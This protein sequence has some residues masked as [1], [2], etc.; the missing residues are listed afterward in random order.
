MNDMLKKTSITVAFL[1]LAVLCC[2]AGTWKIHP[3]F[4]ANKL[5]NIYD[6]GDKVYLLNGGCLFQY[7]KATSSF[8][9]LNQQNV[10]SDSRISQIYFDWENR[11]LFVAYYNSNIDVID[12]IGH[13]TNLS[14]MKDN[15]AKIHNYTFN[16]ENELDSYVGRAI[17]DINFGKGKA[18]VAAGYGF[19]VIDERTLRVEKNYEA[20][21]TVTINSVALMGDTLLV[22]TD[23]RCYYGSPGDSDPIANYKSS[24]GVFS[25]CKLY[26]IN[27]QSVFVYGASNGLYKYSF[28]SGTPKLTRLSTNVVSNVQKSSNGFIVNYETKSYSVFDENGSSGSSETS[29]LSRASAYP[30]GDGTIWVL[31]AGGLH[32]SGSSDCHK[33]NGTT[34]DRPHW[35]K[36]N[37]ELDRLYAGESG[38]IISIYTSTS[39]PNVINT[40]DGTNWENA[41][42]YVAPGAGYE[43]VFSPNDAHTY[44]RAS[45]NNGLFKVKDNVKITNY[46]TT[47]S[48]IRR[49]KPTPAF[50]KYGNLWVVG[51]FKVNNDDE[52]NSCV[53]LPKA[54]FE[55][56]NSLKGD[57]FVPTSLR[58]LTTGSMQRSR[59]IV[60]SKNN[61]KIFSD[62]DFLKGYFSGHIMCWD[63]GVED[64]TVDNYRFVSL[65]KFLD[66]N[67]KVIDWR[68]LSHFE[69]DKDGMIWAGHTLG[70]FF[71]DPEGVFDEFPHAVRPTIGTGYLCEGHTVYD[72]GVDRDNNKW[73]AS[74][75]GVYFVSPDG[76]EVYDHFTAENSD[77]PSNTVYSVEC[78]TLNGRVYAFT[79]N[80]LVEYVPNGDVAALNFNDVYVLPN[81]VEPDFT[82]LIKIGNLMEHSY[83]TITDGDGNIVA[84]LGPAM[85]Y[86]LWDGCGTDGDRVPSGVYNI[87]AAQGGQPTTTGT[88]QATVII[89]K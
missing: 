8:T 10:L 62:C 11:M 45:W 66:Q 14:N 37:A 58:D 27:G 22:L 88:P 42:A 56:V 59:F 65:G 46:T 86:V 19:V 49:Y 63:N 20:K 2:G 24:A 33:I 15:I 77:L 6:T 89:I 55:K 1:L 78:D 29:T 64:P 4:N 26:P 47:N 36:Y 71:F 18:Y 28:S 81:P 21:Q 72:I 32:V 57:W 51:S 40:Y 75:N 48:K 60:A 83:V 7:D 85:G 80:G 70:V 38:P 13:V 5:E 39:V 12:S 73:I 68:Y 31:D 52:N 23:N 50:D 35:L 9:A 17:R 34:T 82:S 84:Q 67:H 74:N 41:T 61:L 87:Y 25:D 3:F 43:F 69:E 79:D 16:E 30:L 44:V 76:S 53:V 54:K